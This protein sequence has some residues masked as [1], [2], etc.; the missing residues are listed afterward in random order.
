[1]DALSR[2]RRLLVSGGSDL[3]SQAAALWKELGRLLAAEKGLVVITGGRM[4]A[5]GRVGT[6]ADWSLV[7]AMLE[8]LHAAGIPPEERIETI[9][10]D[11]AT[12]KK[13]NRFREGRLRVLQ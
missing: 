10:P 12:S 9:L 3:R 11:P 7:E 5:E 2:P 13:T 8:A 1:M 6:S 4:A